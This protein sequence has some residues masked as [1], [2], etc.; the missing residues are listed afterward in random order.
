MKLITIILMM[1]YLSGCYHYKQPQ[2][3]VVPIHSGMIEVKGKLQLYP[4]GVHLIAADGNYK[5]DANMWNI[6]LKVKGYSC[7]NAKT[8]IA[9]LD[10]YEISR[11]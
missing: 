9:I 10:V 2:K 8:G 6:P 1:S 11:Q 7:T 4:D 3:P 5:L